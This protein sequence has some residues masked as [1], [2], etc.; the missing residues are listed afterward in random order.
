MIIFKAG[1]KPPGYDKFVARMTDWTYVRDCVLGSL[2]YF[3]LASAFVYSACHYFEDYD[4]ASQT[5]QDLYFRG[6][7]NTTYFAPG[8]LL[9][10]VCLHAFGYTLIALVNCQRS[11]PFKSGNGDHKAF[12][13][14]LLFATIFYFVSGNVTMR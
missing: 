6:T 12:F 13:W 5:Y 1:T 7:V 14:T 3:V 11:D 2:T 9:L 4:T 8:G 10:Y